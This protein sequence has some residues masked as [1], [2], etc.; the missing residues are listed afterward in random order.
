MQLLVINTPIKVRYRRKSN[1]SLMKIVYVHGIVYGQGYGYGYGYGSG[2]GS[3][4]GYEYGDVRYKCP[5]SIKSS[6]LTEYYT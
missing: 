6:S 4:Y 5:E 1:S 3:G 2:Y